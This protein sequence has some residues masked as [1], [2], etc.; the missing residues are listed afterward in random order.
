VAV[1]TALKLSIK[2]CWPSCLE[3]DTLA[4]V[5]QHVFAT[6]YSDCIVQGTYDG[7]DWGTPCVASIMLIAL[8][9]VGWC[10][11]LPV[12]FVLRVTGAHQTSI[13]QGLMP[14]VVLSMFLANAGL[15]LLP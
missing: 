6:F 1:T 8:T 13:Y 3:Y 11:L 10:V 14:H 4:A 2:L 7:V 15:A 12:S 9:V 5:V